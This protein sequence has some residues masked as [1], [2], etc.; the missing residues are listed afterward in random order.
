MPAAPRR[1]Y[2]VQGNGCSGAVRVWRNGSAEWR[3]IGLVFRV[4]TAG[5]QRSLRR[6]PTWSAPTTCRRSAIAIRFGLQLFHVKRRVK[7]GVTW[8]RL[9]RAGVTRKVPPH[10]SPAVPTPTTLPPA[11]HPPRRNSSRATEDPR[12]NQNF[13]PVSR[14]P[15]C[16]P[17]LARSLHGHFGGRTS[18]RLSWR[19]ITFHVKHVEC[20]SLTT[21]EFQRF[22]L[23]KQARPPINDSR[24]MTVCRERLRTTR[25]VLNHDENLVHCGTDQNRH[26]GVRA[27]GTRRHAGP[28]VVS[29]CTD[30]SQRRRPCPHSSLHRRLVPQ[31]NLRQRRH[32]PSTRTSRW[33]RT[34]TDGNAQ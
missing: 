33:R 7:R 23:P 32:R 6:L 31:Q 12:R 30:D 4:A 8:R 26:V 25:P 13:S 1:L 14:G 21:H 9:F 17:G 16:A 22:P 15:A 24:G 29:A 3:A 2:K 10:H 28:A 11:K 18:S 34:S 5:A 20:L 19:A 27:L